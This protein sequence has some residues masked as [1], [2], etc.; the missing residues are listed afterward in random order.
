[1]PELPEVEA[2]RRGI[3]DQLLNKPIIAT[4]LRRPGLIIADDGLSIDLLKGHLITDTFR[5][6]KYLLLRT[7]PLSLVVH[8]KLTGQFVARGNGIPGFAAGHPV[9]AYDAE[10]PHK[11][12]HLW[13]DFEDDARLFLTDIRHFARIWLL[14]HDEIEEYLRKLRLGP[15]LLSP[16]FTLERFREDLKRRTVGRIKPILLDQTTVAGLGN[17]YVDE[18]LWQALIHPT[19]TAESLSDD[20]IERIYQGI[21]DTMRVAVPAGGARIK[22]STALTD[23]GEFPY[24][25]AREGLPCQ[26]CGTPI[27]KTKV[28]NRGTYLCTVC[29]PEP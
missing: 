23:L 5:H 7:G 26:R 13:L 4:E 28:N 8:L 15:D 16:E 9:P 6:G 29:Q 21:V 17:I 1:V 19:R 10:L 25:H 3:H 2:A 14:P 11:S 27:V 20:E 12:T 22:H 24:V 18:A